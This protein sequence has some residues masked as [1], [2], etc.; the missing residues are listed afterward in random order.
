ML[1]TCNADPIY[2]L[3]SATPMISV[4]RRPRP[5][6]NIK[7]RAAVSSSAPASAVAQLLRETDA[8]AEVHNTVRTG[9]PVELVQG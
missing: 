4:Y 6:T 8:V 5:A 9:V 1:Q 2:G 3:N 7:Y